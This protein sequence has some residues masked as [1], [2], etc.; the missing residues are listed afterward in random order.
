MYSINKQALS[1]V[2][3]ELESEMESLLTVLDNASKDENIDGLIKS[4][5]HIQGVFSLLEIVGG[6]VLISEIVALLQSDDT[7]KL[8]DDNWVVAASAIKLL[9]RYFQQV[10]STEKDN[11]LLLL[12]EINE[13]RRC[14]GVT[15][16]DEGFFISE[17]LPDRPVVSLI[18]SKEPAQ[19]DVIRLSR[20]LFQKGLVHAVRGNGRKAAV[21]IMAHGIHRLRKV[22]TDESELL[23]WSLVFEVLGALYR[24][25]L[26]FDQTRL[27]CLMA[28]ER[29]LKMLAENAS[30]EKSYPETQQRG[31]V[32]HFSLSGCGTESAEKLR[33]R[34]EM[35]PLSFSAKDISTQRAHMV[36]SG[37]A[38]FAET[39]LVL[40]DKH[41]E[42]S[43]VLDEL[44]LN[45]DENTEKRGALR[46]GF[47]ST[48]E[49]CLI[50]GLSQ[51]GQRCR[52]HAEKL[53]A[54]ASD[55]PIS[56]ELI[57][58]MVNTL[59]YLDSVI[60]KLR[61]QS[62]SEQQL[63]QINRQ[64]F[65]TIIEANVVNHAERRVLQEA[66]VNLAEIIRISG[67]YCDG[68]SDDGLGAGGSDKP[69]LENFAAIV[70]SV[71]I[72]GLA[73]ASAV[74]KRCKTY[75]EQ[76]FVEGE[77]G[78]PE[79]MMDVFAD[80]IV[81]L[82]YYLDNCRWNPEFDDS[83]LGVAENCLDRLEAEITTVVS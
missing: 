23:Y 52:Q 20:H 37:D 2:R 12:H 35:K 21:K 9:P 50:L 33:S 47:N 80:A 83:V 3:D 13:L 56:E 28:V 64:A 43:F 77:E 38:N 71:D 39:M 42:L 66:L 57:D 34:L 63:E 10:V 19:L 51:V 14:N 68:M 11:P 30:H 76:Y 5:S 69:I 15:L 41:D 44:V 4:L 29:Q 17:F 32:A 18:M 25:A 61:D 62:P 74:A 55:M 22:M 27:R 70:G 53:E 8:C 24:G 72:L 75:F 46:E 1:L 54:V 78:V 16:R 82:E 60:V 67:D 31:M 45:P 81:S 6:D 73:R 49:I 40:G 58:D 59:L 48:G 79:S 65:K 26:S 36:A 7:E